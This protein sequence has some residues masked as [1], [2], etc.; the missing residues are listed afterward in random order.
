MLAVSA[1]S[2]LYMSAT[3]ESLQARRRHRVLA[4]AGSDAVVPLGQ[5]AAALAP[6]LYHVFDAAVR[7]IAPAS[8]LHDPMWLHVYAQAAPADSDAPAAMAC[9]AAADSSVEGSGSAALA[10]LMTMFERLALVWQLDGDPNPLLHALDSQGPGGHGGKCT[11]AM[12]APSSL[13]PTPHPLFPLASGRVSFACPA[14]LLEPAVALPHFA[15]RTSVAAVVAAGRA[16]SADGASGVAAHKSRSSASGLAPVHEG[17]DSESREGEEELAAGSAPAART[18]AGASSGSSAGLRDIV[19]PR[20]RGGHESLWSGV[21]LAEAAP[22]A[23][24]ATGGAGGAGVGSGTPSSSVPAALAAVPLLLRDATGVL[25]VLQHWAASCWWVRAH[26]HDMQ[27]GRD[28]A[29]VPSQASQSDG[30]QDTGADV[31]AGRGRPQRRR[32]TPRFRRFDPP[33]VTGTRA[34]TAA[35]E[36]VDDVLAPD[37]SEEDDEDADGRDDETSALPLGAV[38]RSATQHALHDRLCR[39][40]G[41]RREEVSSVPRLALPAARHAVSLLHRWLLGYACRWGI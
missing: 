14:L 33:A 13:A 20:P 26:G 36:L 37:S 7:A 10:A 28:D 39:A 25:V 21:R 22:A 34:L 8:Q 2:P 27:V 38:P 30:E 4:A 32:Q 6:L 16:S 1:S 40:M 17:S 31:D 9:S 24:A 15:V 3:H 19:I 11:L 23:A 41:T 29:H 18:S 5:R 12:A 35:L